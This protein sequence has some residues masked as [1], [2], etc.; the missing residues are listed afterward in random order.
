[1]EEGIR[2]DSDRRCWCSQFLRGWWFAPRR[3][4]ACSQKGCEQQSA[5][6]KRTAERAAAALNIDNPSN[7]GP[8]PSHFDLEPAG[9]FTCIPDFSSS[10]FLESPVIKIWG[11][12][13]LSYLEY[14]NAA[15]VHNVKRTVPRLWQRVSSG[16]VEVLEALWL[17]INMMQWLSK[18]GWTFCILVTTQNFLLL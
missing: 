11:A 8:P 9:L 13:H 5:T 10:W 12:D 4:A 16:S 2:V 14:V 1:M 6:F 15:T 18:H 7:R 17:H 3:V